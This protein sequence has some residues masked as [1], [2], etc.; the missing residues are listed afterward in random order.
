[1]LQAKEDA[2]RAAESARASRNTQNRRSVEVDPSTVQRRKASLSPGALAGGFCSANQR[3]S[4]NLSE[5]VDGNEPV[6]IRRVHITMA[7]HVGP[8][9]RHL[10][11]VALLAG[12]LFFCPPRPRL[13][14]AA[15]CSRWASLGLRLIS[16]EQTHLPISPYERSLG[17]R[18]GGRW[19]AYICR[20]PGTGRSKISAGGSRRRTSQAAHYCR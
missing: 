1:M 9:C 4:P 10:A 13:N 19:N 18:P 12:A 20:V 2:I 7:T 5:Y 14:L 11:P 8:S 17:V 6:R 16:F 15:T 3:N